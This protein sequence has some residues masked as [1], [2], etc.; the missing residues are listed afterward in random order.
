MKVFLSIKE[1]K[2]IVGEA[3]VKAK[4]IKA[5]ARAAWH[6]TITDHSW[7]R[8]CCQQQ[9]E[10]HRLDAVHTLF[11]WKRHVSQQSLHPK[12]SWAWSMRKNIS[13]QSTRAEQWALLIVKSMPRGICLLLGKKKGRGGRT[14]R[15]P[16]Q[17]NLQVSCRY[18]TCITERVKSIL[19][20]IS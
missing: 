5:A 13:Q 7:S 19:S 3:Y 10:C 9:H 12:P 1:K 11:H 8:Q 15:G 16:G 17:C 4:N 14:M 18:C 6:S 2:K 20:I